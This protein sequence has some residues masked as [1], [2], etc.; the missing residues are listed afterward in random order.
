M[1]FKFYLVH[2]GCLNKT[3]IECQL[4]VDIWIHLVVPAKMI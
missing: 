1:Q 2:E 3:M 4:G